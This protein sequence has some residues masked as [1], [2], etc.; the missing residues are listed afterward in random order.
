MLRRRVLVGF[1]GLVLA[2]AIASS[3]VWGQDGFL[4]SETQAP[5][6]PDAG[7]PLAPAAPGP[8]PTVILNPGPGLPSPRFVYGTVIDRDGATLRLRDLSSGDEV[9]LRVPAGVTVWRGEM[10]TVDEIVAGDHVTATG[11]PQPDGVIV[12]RIIDVNTEQVR[13]PVV[14]VM[15]DGSWLVEERLGSAGAVKSGRLRRV[16]FDPAHPPSDDAGNPLAI[17]GLVPRTESKGVIVIGMA[18]PDGSMRATKLMYW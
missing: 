18:L 5:L 6:S 12:A 1:A 17:E 14:Q 3:I 13:G 15:A 9:T 8:S 11:D 4:D 10:V 7:A 16:V 2:G